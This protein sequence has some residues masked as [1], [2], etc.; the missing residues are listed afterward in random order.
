MRKLMLTM[1][2]V[3][4]LALPVMGQFG[5]GGRGQGGDSLLLNKSVQAELKLTDDQKKDLTAIQKKATDEGKKAREAFQDMDFE[6]GREIMQKVQKETATALTK[7]KKTLSKTQAK[8]FLEIEVQ[9]AT[10]NT[11]PSIFSREEVQT[12]IKLTEQQKKANK[13]TLEGLEEDV[14]E[15]M[16]DAK[17]DFTKMRAAFTKIGKLRK[18]AYEKITK[19]LTDEQ[20]KAWKELGG[21]EFEYKSDFTRTG[22]GKDKRKRKA[23]DDE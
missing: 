5:F 15:V 10:K 19:S 22:K 16:D 2:L 18:T 3:G 13:K 6:K 17:G 21:K 4:L 9:L 11:T 1:V 7:F 8:R 23:K 12:G 14:K 20:K